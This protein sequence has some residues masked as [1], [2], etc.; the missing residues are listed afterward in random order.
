DTEALADA[1]PYL[2]AEPL[3]IGGGRVAGVDQ[4]IGVL[5]RHHRLAA[6]QTAAASLVDQ[7]PR[8]VSWRVGVGRAAG[9]RPDR[10]RGLARRPDLGHALAVHRRVGGSAAR[11]PARS[12]GSAG[13]NNA[14]AGPPTRNQVIGPTGAFAVSRPRTGG[15]R[16]I[17]PLPL[18]PGV[19]MRRGSGH[20]AAPARPAGYWPNR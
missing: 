17:R 12:S 8:L 1:A 5:F 3:D 16:R 4:K 15:S 7:L 14:S 6:G 9:A 20:R 18:S 11:N 10:L 19:V 2:L 13:R